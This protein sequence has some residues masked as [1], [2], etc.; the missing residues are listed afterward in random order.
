LIR[1]G[2]G[3]LEAGRVEGAAA[4][5][6]RGL[7]LWRGSPL[8]DLELDASVDGALA[9]LGELRLAAL[10][11]RFEAGLQLG[12]HAELVP[13][14]EELVR[15]HPLR[16][17]ARGQLM[18]ALYRGGRQAEA[19]Q[20]Y[21]DA[22]LLLAEELGLE[23][24]PELRRLEKASSSTTLP[25]PRPS[26]AGSSEPAGVKASPRPSSRLRPRRSSFSAASASTLTHPSRRPTSSSSER[27]TWP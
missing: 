25:W 15:E 23:P 12:R 21:R 14:I 16:E 20:T 13:E 5:L 3:A 11:D 17:R 27:T 1:E 8:A 2:R 9:R 24:G 26:P 4:A 7:A 6:D 18:I 22:R 10:E 19:L